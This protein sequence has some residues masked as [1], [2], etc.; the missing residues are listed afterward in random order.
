M[1]VSKN[2]YVPVKMFTILAWV[3]RPVMR[4]FNDLTAKRKMNFNANLL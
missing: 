3:I 2:S 1:K 4:T